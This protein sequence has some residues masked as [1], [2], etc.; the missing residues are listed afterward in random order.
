MNVLSESYGSNKNHSVLYLGRDEYFSKTWF[1]QNLN[2]YA[3]T[4]QTKLALHCE[5]KK[6]PFKDFTKQITSTVLPGSTYRLTL[7]LKTPSVPDE[8]ATSFKFTVG[9]IRQPISESIKLRIKVLNS[10]DFLLN[11]NSFS[12][13]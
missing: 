10:N 3:W 9:D 8:Y 6:S 1:I 4:K 12:N 7:N 13:P 5:D 2:S 11:L